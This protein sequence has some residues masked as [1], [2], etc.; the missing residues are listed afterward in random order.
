VVVLDLAAVPILAV[1]VEILFSQ[2]SPLLVVVQE[3]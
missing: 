1:L 3:V 2:L